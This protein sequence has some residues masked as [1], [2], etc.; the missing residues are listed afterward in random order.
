MTTPT[1]PPR[2]HID[3]PNSPPLFP[4][5]LLHGPARPLPLRWRFTAITGSGLAPWGM[6]VLALSLS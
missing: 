5:L 4:V 6:I 3:L 1:L 2:V